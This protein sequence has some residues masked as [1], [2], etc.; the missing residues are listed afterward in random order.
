[1]EYI[2]F[3][4]I[5]LF[6]A[7][8]AFQV[9]PVLDHPRSGVT[10]GAGFRVRIP[11]SRH[12]VIRF[13]LDSTSRK[14]PQPNTPE[15]DRDNYIGLSL[16]YVRHGRDWDSRWYWGGGAGWLVRDRLMPD[17]SLASTGSATASLVA[18][19]VL[20][21]RTGQFVSDGRLELEALEGGVAPTT[22]LTVG[23]RHHFRFE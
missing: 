17:L 7:E 13:R 1:M 23:Y 20:A 8:P 10:V 18:G 4:F 15:V 2:L 9:Y 12:D 16:A 21:V 19:R 6:I 5:Y 14:P 22:A 3:A 11:V